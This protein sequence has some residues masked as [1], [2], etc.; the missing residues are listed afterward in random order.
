[1]NGYLLCKMSL[2]GELKDETVSLTGPDFYMRAAS[3][4]GRIEYLS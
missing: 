2:G 3:D 4:M 1:M